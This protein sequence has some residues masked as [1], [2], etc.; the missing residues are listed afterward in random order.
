METNEP[1][2][3]RSQSKS[4]TRSK[5]GSPGTGNNVQ[6]K[7]QNTFLIL[8]RK[9]TILTILSLISSCVVFVGGIMNM[10]DLDDFNWKVI[11][12]YSIILDVNSNLL[13]IMLSNTFG[14]EYYIKALG[15]IDKCVEDNCCTTQTR[16]ESELSGYMEETKTETKRS[17]IVMTPTKD[18][19][20]ELQLDLSRESEVP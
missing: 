11:W 20:Q 6:Q 9:C 14:H 1:S 3:V 15:C 4:T 17:E 19:D 5:S 13:C 7:Q 18:D 10:L 16:L 12:G 8:I 2:R